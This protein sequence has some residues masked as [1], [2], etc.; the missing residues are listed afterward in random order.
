M[1]E[2]GRAHRLG[3]IPAH[4]VTLPAP[5]WLGVSADDATEIVAI[6]RDHLLSA[7]K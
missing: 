3:T 4:T 7:L 2:N 1:L 6:T 5:P